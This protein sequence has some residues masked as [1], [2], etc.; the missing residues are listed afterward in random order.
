MS[1]RL[2]LI[3]AVVLLGAVLAFFEF[4]DTDVWLQDKFHVGPGDRWIVEHDEGALCYWP[5]KAVMIAT[6]VLCGIG[7]AASLAFARLDRLCR[8]LAMMSLSFALVPSV[9]VGLREVTNVHGPYQLQRYGMDKPYVK[10]FE[11]A[12]ADL[13]A[14]SRRP[15]R[16]FPAGHASA[17]FPL[18]MLFFVFRRPSARWLGLGVGLAAGWSMGLYQMLTGKHF[19]SHTVAT[20]IGAWI[21]I[22]LS[23]VIFER[24]WPR[25]PAPADR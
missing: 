16:C 9:L 8:P 25:N 24:L 18:M 14:K 5:L 3:L 4:T 23:V 1:P 15:G 10:V 13:R 12:Q 22:L 11:R 2:Q 20:M 6:G 7:L 19:L 17:G 21:L